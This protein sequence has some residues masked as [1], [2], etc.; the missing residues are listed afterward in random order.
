MFLQNRRFTDTETLLEVLFDLELGVATPELE[1]SYAAAEKALAGNAAFQEALASLED[2]EDRL[3][4][5]DD[6]K[7]EAVAELLQ[8]KFP[9]FKV[10]DLKLWG[11]PADGTP[12]LLSSIDLV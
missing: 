4:E 12:V 10:E 6:A 3:E 9:Q 8:E 1:A 2:E 5:A 11:M 7:R